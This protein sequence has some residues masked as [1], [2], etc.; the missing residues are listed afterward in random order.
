M[1][2]LLTIKSIKP[3]FDLLPKIPMRMR[4]TS[5][6]L[7]GFLFQANAEA[8]Y[9]QSARIS[10]EMNNATV[11][12]V[13]NEI[14]AK[15]EFY[16][17]YNNKLIN[18]DRRVS[19]DVDAE[20]I[21]SVL[22]N[23]FKGTDVV[24][25]IADKQ[26]V[27]SRK[28]LAQN[29]AIDGIQQSKVVTGTVVDPTGMPVIG[30]NIMVKG[31]TNGTITDMDGNFSLEADKDAILVV[32]YIG[33]ANQEIKVGNQSKLSIALKED[34][35][36]L[37]ELVVVGY[38]VQ[39]KESLTSAITSVDTEKLESRSLTKAATALQGI[40]PGV[41]IRQTTGRPGFS[42]STF[43]IRGAS[44][45]TFSS[46]PPL[47][48]IDGMV[49]EI[50]N[51]SPEDI[52]N[53]SILKD[54]AAAAIYGSRAT[55]GVVLITTKK[56][57]SGKAQVSY[58]GNVGFQQLAMLNKLKYLNTA[59]WM[60]ANN[61][62]SR[63][64]GSGDIYSAEE[65]AKYENSTNPLYP[66]KSQ[67]TDWYNTTALQHTHSISLRTGTDKLKFYASGNFVQQDGFVD[68]DDYKKFNFLMNVDYKP[69]ER[70]EINTSVSFQRENITRPASTYPVN[71]LMRNAICNPPKDPFYLANGEYNNSATL[72]ANPAYLVK[73]GGNC[74]YEFNRLRMA[75]TARYR[76]L[77]GLYIKY[78]GSTSVNYDVN[79]SFYK[80][81]PYIDENGNIFGYNRQDVRV[82]EDWARANY[83][84][85]LVM[86]DYTKNIHDNHDIYVMAGFQ[87]EENRTDN[88]GASANK[89]PT[90]EIREISGTSG[91]GSDIVGTSKATEW[92]I[93]SF[94]GKANYTFK[95]KYI[96]EG[97]IRYD[98]SS[99]FSP[100]RKW[101]LF[102]SASA[103]W[104]IQ[105]ENFMQSIDWLSNLKLRLSWGQ[106]GNQGSELY[107]FAIQISTSN[108]YPFGNGLSSIAQI[109]SPVDLNLSWEK[110]TTTNIGLDYGF[111]N[112]KLSG[113]VD[114]FFDRTNGIIG[115]PVVPSTFGAEAPIQNC[116]TI[117]NKGY[118]IELKWNDQ[119]GDFKYFISANFFDNRDKIVSL[120]GIGSYD[121]AFGD[122]LV[123]KGSNTYNAEGKPRNSLYLYR[124]NG[125]FVDQNEI[126]N[127][128]FISNLTRPGD[129]AFID[130]NQDG[131][132]T[133][134][135][136][137]ADNRTTTPH[138]F[139]GFSF[140]GSY[141]NFD[142]MAVFNGVGQ[143]WDYRNNRGTYLT[144]VRASL[145]ILEDNYNNRWTEANPDKFAD[146]PR[147]TQNNWIA[148]E[149][150]TLFS[151][152]CEYHLRNFGY[153]R[154]KNLQVGYTIP[155]TWL[156]SL[157]ISKLRC[158][159]T[160]EN[161][162]TIAPGYKEHI[163]PESV[164]NFTDD[165]SAFFGVPRVVSFGVQVN[166]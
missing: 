96:F 21:E 138:Y 136:K 115:R 93:A 49:D 90:N 157:R 105:Q 166:F 108:Q 106:L 151:G 154:L 31:T 148:N 103:S 130:T 145:S 125:L 158:Y 68:N 122:G 18:V 63:L 9:S 137:V 64:D 7:A 1:K 81:I 144:G 5:V 36:A 51:V 139:Y 98:G 30:A 52:E 38:G 15:S 73:E 163:D 6:L 146:Q 92:S 32:S 99:R 16:F 66:A 85:N 159:L 160:A 40:T 25:R 27:L 58:S 74:L 86:L 56:G 28:D 14:E 23:L 55:G 80:K 78:S 42:A 121:P 111:F 8:S 33:F 102:P 141:K 45:G 26:I 12:E 113:S 75:I 60:R 101:G 43:D 83:Y 79:N 116:Y 161:L 88:I 164:M 132:V 77:D 94:I 128:A 97:T 140:G 150:S 153:L 57:Q 156:E 37:D 133:P 24:Y 76:L 59:D 84:N 13:L 53:I 95:N 120:G 19:V 29:T 117:D 61:E 10:I 72:G 47:V 3:S 62:A 109:G 107:P 46:N 69:I 162:L 44:M 131:K 50:D 2:K 119:I 152:P 17:L 165:G 104:R 124:T 4:I 11:E 20:N 135:D 71:D 82:S 65:I 54:A 34:A 22:Q 123:Q 134:E 127:H 129:I 48:L 67:W 91:S 112:N 155:S 41:N 147:L 87:S 142:F 70:L 114:V 35:E 118:E 39:K 89:F 126:D 100:N 110:K 143:R 149:Y